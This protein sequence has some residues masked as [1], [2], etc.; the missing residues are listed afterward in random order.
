MEE[1]FDLPFVNNPIPVS[2]TNVE[3]TGYNPVSTVNDLS[4]LFVAKAFKQHDNGQHD[5]N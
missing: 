5:Q 4:D 3:G 1:I 2:E